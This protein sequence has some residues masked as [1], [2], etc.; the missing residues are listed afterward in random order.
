MLG[1]KSEKKLLYRALTPCQKLRAKRCSINKFL[2]HKNL[3]HFIK[4]FIKQNLMLSCFSFICTCS[5]TCGS[6]AGAC[7]EGGGGSLD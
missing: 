7:G 5:L 4:H 2:S 3:K 1:R 6:I